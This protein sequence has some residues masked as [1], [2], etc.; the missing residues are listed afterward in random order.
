MADYQRYEQEI[1]D[2][3]DEREQLH[4][5]AYSA[6]K[7]AND[8]LDDDET[9]L[10]FGED[11]EQ[12]IKTSR[13]IRNDLEKLEMLRVDL[14]DGEIEDEKAGLEKLINGIAATKEKVGAWR[15]DLASRQ[16]EID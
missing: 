5:A 15:T 11:D 10:Q 8:E 6:F 16:I 13:A 14:E 1:D 12:D 3:E 4:D 7:E 2:L 9:D